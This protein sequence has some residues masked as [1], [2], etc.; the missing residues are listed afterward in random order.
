[1]QEV[2]VWYHT[3]RGRVELVQIRSA[4]GWSS[5]VRCVCSQ[6]CVPPERGRVERLKFRSA[7]GQWATPAALNKL[8]R[9]SARRMTSAGEPLQDLESL[10]F[11]G[12]SADVDG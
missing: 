8:A 1:V 10:G 5:S 7:R 4:R 12:S 3:V 6:C 2:R 9:V 11:F